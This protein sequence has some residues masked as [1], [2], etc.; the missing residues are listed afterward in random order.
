MTIEQTTTLVFKSEAGDYFLVPQD[1]IERGRVPEEYKTEIEGLLA[2]AD[3]DVSGYVVETGYSLLRV[4]NAG[5]TALGD[6]TERAA[7]AAFL[8]R[9]MDLINSTGRV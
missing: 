8:Q 4:I 7:N 9:M 5:A 3:E 1:S 2:E 6:A